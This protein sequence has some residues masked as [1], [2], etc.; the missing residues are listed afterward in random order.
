MGVRHERVR[1]PG[2]CGGRIT[3]GS[4][5]RGGRQPARKSHGAQA[6]EGNLAQTREDRCAEAGKD[7]AAQTRKSAETPH[8]VIHTP[9]EKPVARPHG[10]I[11]PENGLADRRDTVP[12]VIVRSWSARD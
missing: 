12:G 6:G 5:A 7:D 8:E 10:V 1:V 9:H 11:V 3:G 2:S 4:D